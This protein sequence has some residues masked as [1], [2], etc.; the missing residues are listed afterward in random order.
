VQDADGDASGVSTPD[1]DFTWD[2]ETDDIDATPSSQPFTL[3][4]LD[5]E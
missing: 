1:S 5:D 4:E 3:D 2:D